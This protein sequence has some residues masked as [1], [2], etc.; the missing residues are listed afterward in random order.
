MLQ[1][2]QAHGLAAMVLCVLLLFTLCIPL[3]A[4]YPTHEHYLSDPDNVLSETTKS[5]IQTIN[6]TLDST[7]GVQ[8]AVCITAGTGSETITEFS[9]TLFSKWEMC[10]GVL[11]V[12]DTTNQTYFA[13]QSVDIDDII[14][15]AVLDNI[16]QTST[17]A[18]FAD[19]NID[20]AVMKTVTALSQTMTDSLP[21]PNASAADDKKD[22]TTPTEEEEKKPSGFV[23]FM[24]VILWILII[25]VLV[26]AGI[27]VIALF[28]DDVA[29]L[30]RTYVFRRNAPQPHYTNPGYYDDRLYGNKHPNRPN[31]N[32]QAPHGGQYGGNGQYAGQRR[33]NPRPN[34]NAYDPYND[35]EQ[36]YRQPQ[37]QGQRRQNPN[38]Q[39][40]PSN[41][42]GQNYGA[43]NRN[44]NGQY[45][46]SA[47]NGR[48]QNPPRDR[49]GY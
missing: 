45:Q 30:L 7:R 42:N 46:G 48:R 23:T 26:A 25:A 5:A 37:Y 19:G 12:F 15:N 47:Q 38:A 18:D 43:Q 44:R 22:D 49:G 16:F 8:I 32:R 36:Q 3:A 40:Y 17:E 11:L 29:D 27:F 41:C 2:K 28:N 13:V 33:P 9:R 31:Q 34:P 1:H 14:T 10:D 20:R 24:K 4:A 39:N 21:D 6:E 35:Y